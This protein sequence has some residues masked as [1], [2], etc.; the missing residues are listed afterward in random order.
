MGGERHG[1]HAQ[2]SLTNAGDIP[3]GWAQAPESAIQS[4]GDQAGSFSQLSLQLW[5]SHDSFLGCT[6]DVRVQGHVIQEC[7][8]LNIRTLKGMNMCSP[9]WPSRSARWSAYDNGRGCSSQLGP[10]DRDLDSS[11]KSHT[12]ARTPFPDASQNRTPY[13]LWAAYPKIIKRRGVNLDFVSATVFW[14]CFARAR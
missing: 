11:K 4:H 13:Q 7:V 3:S 8:S 6:P 9:L 10:R 1:E 14:D 12:I 2:P 5:D